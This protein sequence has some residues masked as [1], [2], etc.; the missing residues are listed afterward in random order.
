MADFLHTSGLEPTLTS[1][2]REEAERRWAAVDLVSPPG[3]DSLPI[4]IGSKLTPEDVVVAY[5]RGLFPWPPGD[6]ET[7]AR[8]EAELAT[9]L[10]NGD[11]F[12][13][14]PCEPVDGFIVPWYSP[15]QR[16]VLEFSDVH[17][18]K[19]LRRAVRKAGW[20]TTANRSFDAVVDLCAMRDGAE[21]WITPRFRRTYRELRRQG[22]AHSV[23]VWEGEDLVG[24]V[25][26]VASGRVFTGEAT[27]F[28]RSNA[29]KVA[30]LDLAARVMVA[31]GE[32][33]DTQV[34]EPPLARLGATLVER[35]RYLERLE[36]LRD[37]EMDLETG[38][39]DPLRSLAAFDGS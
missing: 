35:D 37:Q 26:G 15:P 13:V 1:E 39:R 18:S 2:A 10:P 19:H 9:H 12:V 3:A 25:F 38:Q 24:G 34:L 4:A 36:E 31:G 14:E 11:V 8:I 21:S 33:L 20:T 30:I 27:F 7:R 5:R 29:S 28:L 16:G 32:F 17:I 22:Y 23:E 6:E